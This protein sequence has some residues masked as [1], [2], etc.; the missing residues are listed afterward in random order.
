M[1]LEGKRGSTAVVGEAC[2]DTMHEILTLE[3]GR[4]GLKTEVGVAPH[5]TLPSVV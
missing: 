1:A 3:E 5:A 2:L 4:W